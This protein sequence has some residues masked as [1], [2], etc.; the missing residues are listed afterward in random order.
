MSTINRIESGPPPPGI[1]QLLDIYQRLSFRQ[2]VNVR[3]D[4]LAEFL[5]Q[6]TGISPVVKSIPVSI[7]FTVFESCHFSVVKDFV[8][9]TFKA[10][11]A[12][13]VI[14]PFY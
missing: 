2:G 11:S 14:S 3:F 13:I 9:L 5:E 10:F 1:L 4:E 7:D 8:T 6:T 12:N